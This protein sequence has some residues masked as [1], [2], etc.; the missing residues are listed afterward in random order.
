MGLQGL[1]SAVRPGVDAE[2]L[3]S[4]SIVDILST[5]LRVTSLMTQQQWKRCQIYGIHVCTHSIHVCA[6]VCMR[7]PEVDTGP[8]LFSTSLFFEAKS[9]TEPGVVW[10]DWLTSEPLGSSCVLCSQSWS[11]RC[12]PAHAALFV[13][14]GSRNPGPQ[15]STG[16]TLPHPST[17]LF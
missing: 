6:H 2:S 1:G 15:A 9:L 13:D 5:G 14:A 7:T 4:T 11:Y 8:T 10:P 3:Y 12:A 17:F 16:S